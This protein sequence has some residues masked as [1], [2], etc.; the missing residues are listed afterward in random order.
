MEKT[1]GGIRLK[2]SV[3]IPVYNTEKYL[4]ECLQSVLN[5]TYQDF[6]IIIVD[7]G[8]T[9]SSG[10]ICDRYQ[11]D[12]SGRIKV[13]HQNNQGQLAS[14]CKAIQTAQGDYVIFV[15]A[16]DL[17]FTDALEIINK[18]LI[19]QSFPDM[20]IYSFYYEDTKGK[21]KPAKR[22]FDEGK[23]EIE[24]LYNEFFTGIGLNC[25]WTKAVKCS[26]AKCDG[27]DFKN[28][29]S[30]RC[31]EDTLHSMVMVDQCKTVVFL[32]QQLYRY[33]LFD[34][35]TTRQY[36]ISRIRYY[37]QVPLYDVRVHYAEKWGLNSSQW[38]EKIDANVISY[39]IYVFDLFYLNSPK[40]ERK[41]I[42]YYSW[43]SFIPD[44]FMTNTIDNNGFLSETQKN[45]FHWIINK[46]KK[47]IQKYYRKKSIYLQIKRIKRKITRQN[48]K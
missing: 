35:S 21:L 15:D 38:K 41:S 43:H 37:N 30:L 42:I 32:Y 27:F 44:T 4:E 23:V 8:S 39:L 47:N 34:C 16:D 9:D 2:F 10:E 11:S 5:Q 12:F 18:T 25:V 13:I 20:L 45:L 36:S 24:K 33:R 40:D 46:D 28:F 26:I 31:A 14:R 19:R 17:L 22:F 29:Y 6:E 48:S 3:L 7:D 1:I